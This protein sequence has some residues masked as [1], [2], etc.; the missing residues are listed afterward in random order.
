MLIAVSTFLKLNKTLFCFDTYSLSIFYSA[1]KLL[2]KGLS[3]FNKDNNIILI[4][5]YYSM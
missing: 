2:F 4:N 3:Y 5:I 1:V